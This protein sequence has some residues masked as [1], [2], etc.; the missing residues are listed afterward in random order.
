[1]RCMNPLL[2]VTITGMFVVMFAKD[3]YDYFLCLRPFW[4]TFIYGF[5]KNQTKNNPELQQTMH[6]VSPPN[7]HYHASASVNLYEYCVHLIKLV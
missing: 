3:K 2:R 7:L 5:T 1:M 4:S 6:G